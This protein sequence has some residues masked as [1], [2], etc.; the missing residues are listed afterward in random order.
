MKTV[1]KLLCLL[2]RI[3]GFVLLALVLPIFGKAIYHAMQPEL[4][5]EYLTAAELDAKLSEILEGD[6]SLKQYLTEV[7]NELNSRAPITVDSETRFDNCSWGPG[8]RL[9]YCYTLVNA[10]AETFDTSAFLRDL[11]PTLVNGC[12]THPD[13][14][15]IRDYST[16][17]RFCYRDKDG[18]YLSEIIVSPTDL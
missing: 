18:S 8:N 13:L 1:G 3:F 5:R 16:I 4:K 14:A 7:C 2:L 10:S 15:P 11:R 9:T 6:A 12:K 17:L